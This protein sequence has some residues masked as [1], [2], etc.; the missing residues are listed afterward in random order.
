MP[1][2]PVTNAASSGDVSPLQRLRVELPLERVTRLV[3]TNVA[4]F[5]DVGCH[6]MMV[7]CNTNCH[8]SATF[9]FIREGLIG[10]GEES[11]LWF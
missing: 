11:K 1:V 2:A 8:W 10:F 7:L 9:R 3:H 4:I 5:G 6:T